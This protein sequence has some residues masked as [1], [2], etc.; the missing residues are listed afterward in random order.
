[1]IP[2]KNLGSESKEIFW[3]SQCNTEVQLIFCYPVDTELKRVR[4]G[5][6]G[7]KLLISLKIYI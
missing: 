7:L 4:L 3:W 2:Q 5:M 6:G 1:M